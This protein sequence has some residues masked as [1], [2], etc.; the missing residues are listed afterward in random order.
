MWSWD[1]LS[2]GTSGPRT[3]CPGGQFNGGDILPYDTST[4]PTLLLSP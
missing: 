4:K 1:Q 3:T 2:G